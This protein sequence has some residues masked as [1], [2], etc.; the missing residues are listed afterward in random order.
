MRGSMKRT[1]FAVIVVLFMSLFLGAETIEKIVVEGN[2]KVSRDTILF[3][4][5][6]SEKGIFSPERLREDFTT[7]WNTGFFENITIEADDGT[8]GKI[9]T[10]TVIAHLQ[11]R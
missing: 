2:K 6:S 8:T 7:L 9:V 3:Y 5:K 1:I 4:M 11:N 10:I